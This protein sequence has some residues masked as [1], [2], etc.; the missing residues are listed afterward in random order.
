M[1]SKS[2]QKPTPKNMFEHKKAE[3][4][5]KKDIKREFGLVLNINHI[6]ALSIK[7]CSLLEF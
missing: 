3:A 4:Q 1:T 7:N 2:W 6:K 5:A